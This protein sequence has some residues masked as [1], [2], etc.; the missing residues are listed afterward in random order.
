MYKARKV[1]HQAKNETT[2]MGRL[3]MFPV[4]SASTPVKSVQTVPMHEYKFYCVQ[5]PKTTLGKTRRNQVSKALL[6]SVCSITKI[7]GNH[8]IIK[9][10]WFR[11]VQYQSFVI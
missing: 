10:V 8:M 6:T 7:K 4:L 5:W 9:S 1:K 11:T 2:D 3:Q